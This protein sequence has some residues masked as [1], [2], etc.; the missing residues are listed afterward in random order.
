MIGNKA[1]LIDAEKL[2]QLHRLDAI[3]EAWQHSAEQSNLKELVR[4]HENL[5]SDCIKVMN[6]IKT[7]YRSQAIKLP[8]RPFIKPRNMMNGW[9]NYQNPE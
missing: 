2:A 8:V 1:D 6:R 5:I 9:R 4:T 7:I 3:R